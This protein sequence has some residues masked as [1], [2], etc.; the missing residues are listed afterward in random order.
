MKQ[1]MKKGEVEV[2]VK[3][4]EQ[5]RSTAY[6][7]KIHTQSHSQVN[8]KNTFKPEKSWATGNIP[9]TS[10]LPDSA[11]KNPYLQLHLDVRYKTKHCAP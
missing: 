9:S 11:N 7:P 10:G 5:P 4:I 3:K 1:R 2:T 6:L 8:A